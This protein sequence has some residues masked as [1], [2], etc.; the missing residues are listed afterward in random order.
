MIIIMIKLYFNPIIVLFLTMS[1]YYVQKMTLKYFNPIIVLFLT[2]VLVSI[3]PI[4][5]F[6]SYYSLIFNAPYRRFNDKVDIFQSYY[7]LI[8]NQYI[9]MV[10]G[11][12]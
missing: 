4:I 3:Q 11:I 9:Y 2:L 6:Q 10:R 8:F 1:M 12:K 5:L 7:S